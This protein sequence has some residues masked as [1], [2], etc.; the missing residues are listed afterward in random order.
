MRR[1][2]GTLLLCCWALS[3]PVRAD[4]PPSRPVSTYSIVARDATTGELGVAVQSHWFSVGAVVPW[5]A[6]GVGAVATQSFVEV[7]YGPQGLAAMR[8]GL[9]AGAALRELVE[10]DD[11]AAV[12]QVAF[13]DAQG[14]TAAHTGESCIPGAG[15][16][17]GDGYSVQANLMLTDAVPQA[18][19]AAYENSTGPLAE[20][21]MA[22]LD[23]A[24]NAGGD[25][26]GRQSAALLV[27]R[28]TPSDKPWTDRLVDLR[29]EDHHRPLEELRRLLQLHRAYELMNEG[30]A[31]EVLDKD[32]RLR[33]M[34]WHFVVE[35]DAEPALAGGEK[36]QRIDTELAD[37]H[38]R[39]GT[40][41]QELP[42][43]DPVLYR[44]FAS[45]IGYDPQPYIEQLG[46]PMLYIFAENDEAVPT[47]QAV[48]YL[49]TLP[50]QEGRDIEIRVIPGV[51]HD[52]LSA[53]ALL[54]GS[55][56]AFIDAIGPWAKAKARNLSDSD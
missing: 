47:A 4:A 22:A 48:A 18:M 16:L 49:Q 38:R 23:A 20:R 28:G 42:D 6:S 54:S 27:V 7:S 2:V 44:S 25:I 45:Y 53:A 19:A 11:H 9:A 13:V 40:Y 14:R 24:Q 35:V 39:H 26:R 33:D 32:I 5:A 43:Y 56:P 51:K 50:V 21:L 31:E 17:S 46:V 52:M 1:H 41:I 37:F 30:V 29:V 8:R 36:W 10:Q 55:D 3:L 12:R 15:H 34:V